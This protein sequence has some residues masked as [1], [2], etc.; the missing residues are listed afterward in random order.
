MESA[1]FALNHPYVDCAHIVRTRFDIQSTAWPME[2]D[3]MPDASYAVHM[4]TSKGKLGF[5]WE[6][7]FDTSRGVYIRMSG[8][9]RLHPRVTSRPHDAP[10]STYS[11][12]THILRGYTLRPGY[13]GPHRVRVRSAWTVALSKFTDPEFFE[14]YPGPDR[15]IPTSWIRRE[16]EELRGCIR[17]CTFHY[18]EHRRRWTRLRAG[19]SEELKQRLASM[20][21]WDARGRRIAKNLAIATHALEH[22]MRRASDLAEA[23]D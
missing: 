3:P 8:P 21:A 17:I 18:T 7:T 9:A 12:D 14:L 1:G 15:A 4:T 23:A 16:I 10:P 5:V 13:T 2:L 19:S 6:W 20:R 11:A 22:Q